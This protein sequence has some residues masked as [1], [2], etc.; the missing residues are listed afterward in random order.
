MKDGL[1][2]V[3]DAPPK[4]IPAP[5]NPE[6]SAAL[7]AILNVLSFTETSVE[8][9]VVV[10]PSTVK[11]PS[12]LTVPLLSPIVAGSMINSAGPLT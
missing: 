8:L 7:S 9:I 6:L 11:L 10:V 1:F 3:I 4:T 5:A 2:A 12:I